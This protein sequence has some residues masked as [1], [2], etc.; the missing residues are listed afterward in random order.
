MKNSFWQTLPKPIIALAPMDG[1]TDHAYRHIQ[2][3]YGNPSL[4]FTEFV[5]VD[6]ICSSRYT[7]FLQP[8][9][10]DESQRPII[11]QI[12]GHIPHL[13]R[14]SAVV[15]CELGFDGIDIN[16]GCPATSIANRGAGAGLIR[17]PKLAQEIVR[18]TMA[19]VTDWRNGMTSADCS[20]IRQAMA[21]YVAEQHSKLPI[22]YRGDAGR[23][24]VIPV[25]VKTRIGYDEPEIDEWVPALLETGPVAISIHGRTLKRKYAGDADWDPIGRAVEL[26]QDS[27]TLILGNGDAQSMTDAKRRVGDY[28]VDGVLIGRASYGNPFV[29]QEE[30]ALDFASEEASDL[31]LRIAVEHAQVYEQ[32]FT[33]YERYYF[34]PMRKHLG[35]YARFAGHGHELKKR[36]HQT[37]SAGEVETI[38]A[39][40]LAH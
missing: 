20:D 3:K 38:L 32:M 29:F 31:F 22:N 9:L 36:L 39:D 34:R 1:I 25:S 35:W 16:M 4:V 21:T 10:Y 33:Q 27:P 13:F 37:E 17:K 6:N 18:E 19:G 23:Q 30:E 26:A 5:S 14:Q 40:Y 12:Y 8:F 28:G 11:G 2:K 24:R 7:R 15:L